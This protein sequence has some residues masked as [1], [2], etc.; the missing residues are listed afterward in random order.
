MSEPHPYYPDAAERLARWH[1]IEWADE[2]QYA[3]T[4]RLVHGLNDEAAR[5]AATADPP[6][7]LLVPPDG[8]GWERNVD[9]ADG[10]W[11]VVVPAWCKD[12]TAV[13][14]RVYWRRPGWGRPTWDIKTHLSVPRKDVQL[15]DELD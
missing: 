8:Q 12:D 13:L 4:Y 6:A 3:K 14:Q 10:G 2:W 5:K 9:C 7:E 15:L 11:D 1:A